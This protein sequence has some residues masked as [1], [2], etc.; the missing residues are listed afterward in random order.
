M[1]IDYAR[2][3]AEQFTCIISFNPPINFWGSTII[4]SVI[5][6]KRQDAYKGQNVS[7]QLEG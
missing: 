6:I 7:P 4:I 5:E 1:F 2:H 3:C